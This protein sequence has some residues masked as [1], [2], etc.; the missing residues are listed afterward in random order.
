MRDVEWKKL[1]GREELSPA[2]QSGPD[3][4]FS[5]SQSQKWIL[6]E[7]NLSQGTFH[8]ISKKRAAPARSPGLSKS[9]AGEP[10]YE[11]LIE[12]LSWAIMRYPRAI[13]GR[14]SIA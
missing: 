2:H 5:F 10:P 4:L 8:W 11:L 6:G 7:G 13:Q 12:R 3:F 1:H 9:D 14:M